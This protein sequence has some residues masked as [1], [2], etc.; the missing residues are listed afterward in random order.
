[1]IADGFYEWK[2]VDSKKYPYYI[3]LKDHEVFSLA[4]I[5]D[6]WSAGGATKNTFS[7]IT[8][9]ANPMMAQIHNTKKRMPVILRREDEKRWLDR[10]LTP[11]QIKA[12]L[13]PYD[14]NGMEAYTVSRIISASGVKRNSPDIIVPFQYKELK[15]GQQKLD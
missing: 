4:G 11:D 2:E 14:E 7:I 5:W 9:D 6:T 3:R 8:T 13:Q 15:S 10:N 1:V 12:L